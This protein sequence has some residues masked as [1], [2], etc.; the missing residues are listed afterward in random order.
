MAVAEIGE[1]KHPVIGDRFNPATRD[2]LRFEFAF[3][4]FRQ[5]VRL[6]ARQ[7]LKPIVLRIDERAFDPRLFFA[8][9]REQLVRLVRR[10][11][12][13]GMAGRR[14]FFPDFRDLLFD[15]LQLQFAALGNRR[16]LLDEFFQLFQLLFQLVYFQFREPGQTEIENGL[17]LDFGQFKA[18]HQTR[19]RV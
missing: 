4:R 2:E 18:R 3:R 1:R 11:N 8:G 14:I 12:Q 15:D 19:A 16:E 5:R 7:H 13:T 17:R 9:M 10:V 6:F